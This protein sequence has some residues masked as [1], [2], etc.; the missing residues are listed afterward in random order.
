MEESLS[1][2]DEERLVEDLVASD[3]YQQLLHRE[4]PFDLFRILGTLSENASSRALAFLLDSSEDH[5]LGTAFFDTLLQT[6]YRDTKGSATGLT[7]RRL[8]GMKGTETSATTEWSTTKGRRIDI[9]VRVSDQAGEIC[10]VLGIENKHWAE[11]QDDQVADYQAELID[12]FPGDIQRL[13]LFLSPGGRP[14]RTAK[15]ADDCPHIE[16]SY[17][18]VVDSLRACSEHTKG[19]LQVFLISLANHL[20][21]ELEGGAE[22]NSDVK[23]LVRTLYKDQNHRRAIRL[24]MESLPTFGAILPRTSDRVF[25]ALED[26]SDEEFSLDTYPKKQVDRLQEIYLMPEGLRKLT[27]PHGFTFYYILHRDHKN[28]GW[29]MPDLGDRVL[30]QLA[31]W[32]KS[33]QGKDA[34]TQLNLPKL[35]PPSQDALQPFEKW[36]PVWVPGTYSLQ[37]FDAQDVQGCSQLLIDAI[38]TTYPILRKALEQQYGTLKTND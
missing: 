6:V 28:C 7:L 10:A 4:S 24:I 16:C 1:T 38:T 23:S 32:C 3:E 36:L 5:G 31:A 35:L 8:L 27:K 18:S 26:V 14:S 29:G 19:P 11:E 30:V 25:A 17:M 9:V 22:M 37:D 2:L 34:V 13:L 15:H 20:E 21:S 33:Q 12:R